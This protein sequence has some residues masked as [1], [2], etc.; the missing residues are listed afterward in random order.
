MKCFST[1]CYFYSDALFTL[2]IRVGQASTFELFC[3]KHRC[4]KWEIHMRESFPSA[5]RIF[6][7]LQKKCFPH[8][9]VG[10]EKLSHIMV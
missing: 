6:D 3:R 7:A 8:P 9:V 10:M 1:S 2:D 5:L 4:N